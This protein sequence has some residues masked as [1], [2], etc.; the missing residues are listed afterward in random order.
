VKTS[1]LVGGIS[2]AF[3]LYFILLNQTL[4]FGKTY[5]AA[6]EFQISLLALLVISYSFIASLERFSQ[7]RLVLIP[8]LLISSLDIIFNSLFF[9]GFPEYYL[10]Y[11]SLRLPLA[12]L[13]G[14]LAFSYISFSS[15]PLYQSLISATSLIVAG[16][17]SYILFSVL[18]SA[19]A[20]PSIAIPSLALFLILAVT[21]ISNAF[22]GDLAEW[23]R[24][25]RSFFILILFILTFYAILIRPLLQDRP[26]IANFFEWVVIAFAMIKLSRDL[27]GSI[28]VDEREFVKAHKL[29]DK[30]I[31][32]KLYSEL[33]FGE[34]AFIE[35]GTKVPL[36]VSLIKALNNAGVD[37]ARIES[38]LTPLVYYN[39]EKVPLL[40]FPWERSIIEK[41]NKR[42]RAEIVED[43]KRSLSEMDLHPKIK[44]SG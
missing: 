4:I 27:R 38:I 3:A 28:E 10:L 26:G 33:E 32:D 31:K 14:S 1:K 12:I 41:R 29:Q 7:F 44:L 18:S 37:T 6:D 43:L 13:V 30:F 15:R 16:I 39:D 42:K 23:I 20:I 34:R 22:E 17:S 8:F 11:S 19:L 24:N 5:I 36:L 35:G 40:S 9:I 21:A 25:E 2:V